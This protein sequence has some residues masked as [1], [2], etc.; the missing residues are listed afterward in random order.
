MTIEAT[1]ATERK[2]VMIGVYSDTKED[3]RKAKRH[4]E[5]VDDCDY[6][7]DEAIRR[8]IEIVGGAGVYKV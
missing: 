7:D 6:S 2:Q 1:E 3:F 4:M 5:S 8:M